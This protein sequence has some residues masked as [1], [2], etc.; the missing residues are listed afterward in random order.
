[1]LTHSNR[2]VKNSIC[3]RDICVF[4]VLS[5]SFANFFDLELSFALK[6]TFLLHSSLLLSNILNNFTFILFN[7]IKFI[8]QN[9][10]IS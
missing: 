9:L 7:Q 3:F 4:Q 10:A 5:T 6:I 1:M 8:F 2:S